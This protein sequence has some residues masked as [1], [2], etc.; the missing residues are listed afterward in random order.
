METVRPPVPRPPHYVNSRLRK[1]IDQTH[2]AAPEDCHESE[3]VLLY[4]LQ[5]FVDPTGQ[6]PV[7]DHPAAPLF[8]GGLSWCV[9]PG[10]V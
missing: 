3:R 6:S 7:S 2:L 9:N 10:L 1:K 4:L 8:Q 5:D